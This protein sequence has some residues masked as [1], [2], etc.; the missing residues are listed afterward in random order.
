MATGKRRRELHLRCGDGV[1]VMMRRARVASAGLLAAE[2]QG[3]GEDARVN[4]GRR[5]KVALRWG[6]VPM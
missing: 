6:V 4:V 5:H 3:R 2:E 1:R